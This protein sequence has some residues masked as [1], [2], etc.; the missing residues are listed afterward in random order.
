M[1][2][3]QAERRELEGST[4]ESNQRRLSPYG[5]KG[6]TVQT[7]LQRQTPCKE[8]NR[9][10]CNRQTK[11][12]IPGSSSGRIKSATALP[13]GAM[14]APRVASRIRRI[15][16]PRPMRSIRSVIYPCA[17][18]SAHAAAQL[19]RWPYRPCP[20]ALAHGTPAPPQDAL[21]SSDLATTPRSWPYLEACA[22]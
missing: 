22:L 21:P 15:F 9:D 14:S 16:Y 17:V 7:K 4:T 6:G 12:K 2:R 19:A 3:D 10:D 11:S 13:G 20:D 8:A 1:E 5:I 18:P